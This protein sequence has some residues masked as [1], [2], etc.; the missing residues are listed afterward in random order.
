M[1]VIFGRLVDG[2]GLFR[3]HQLATAQHTAIYIVAH[4]FL[5]P[6]NP[7]SFRLAGVLAPKVDGFFKL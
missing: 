1:S 5:F 4:N 6:T 3:V 7:F 2:L